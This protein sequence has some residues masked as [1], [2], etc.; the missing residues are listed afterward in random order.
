MALTGQIII[1]NLVLPYSIIAHYSLAGIP[2]LIR[3]EGTPRSYK[4]III[5][6]RWAADKE[7]II[8]LT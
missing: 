1:S 3:Q 4:T 6:I 7:P 2:K 5:L 8:I